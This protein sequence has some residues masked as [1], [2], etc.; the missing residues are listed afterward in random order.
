MVISKQFPPFFNFLIFALGD[1]FYLN[2]YVYVHERICMHASNG[3][4]N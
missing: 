3:P 1:G 2:V 4:Y